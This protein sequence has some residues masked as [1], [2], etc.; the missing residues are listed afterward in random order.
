MAMRPSMKNPPHPGCL[1]RREVLEPL[2]LS[3]SGAA[4]I[5]GV[6][7]SALTSLVN[8]RT[9][10]KFEVALRI[11]KAFGPRMDHLMRMQY[12]YD[13]ARTRRNAASIRVGRYRSAA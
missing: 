3:I 13:F 7:R 10:L 8:G 11:E 6:G 4:T 2:G 12:A 1:I 9:P 5:L